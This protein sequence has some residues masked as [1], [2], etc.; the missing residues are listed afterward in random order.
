MGSCSGVQD[1]VVAVSL[2]YQRAGM[3]CSS[4]AVYAV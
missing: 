3:G 1:L 4:I 2:Q